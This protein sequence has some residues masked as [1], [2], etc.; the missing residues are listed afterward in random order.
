[1]KINNNGKTNISDKTVRLVTAALMCAI[2]VITTMFVPITIPVPLLKGAYLNAGDA[3]VFV[4]AFVLGGPLGACVA[5]VGSALADVFLG[6][7]LY[8]PA[9]FV[10]KGLMALAA[11]AMM[12]KH[13]FIL[14]AI[15]ISGLIM[16]AGYFL[17]EWALLGDVRLALAGAPFNLAQFGVCAAIG[18]FAIRAVALIRKK[19]GGND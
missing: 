11:G 15:L 5:A 16:P 7:F 19:G 6:S 18:Y 17:Y 2:V 13:R 12:K 1:M 4:T 9:T 14:P 10:I 8:A 3:A